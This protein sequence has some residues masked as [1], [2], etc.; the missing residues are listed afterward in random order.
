MK[1]IVLLMG[2]LHLTTAE[3]IRVDGISP[4]CFK[5][6]LCR[7]FEVVGAVISVDKSLPFM[8]AN[9]CCINFTIAS[10]DEDA[11]FMARISNQTILEGDDFITFY[12]DNFKMIRNITANDA[13]PFE[14]VHFNSPRISFE[15]YKDREYRSIYEIIVSVYHEGN[16]PVC[17]KPNYFRCES[18]K[19]ICID[20]N[21]TCDKFPHCPTDRDEN[22]CDGISYETAMSYDKETVIIVFVFIVGTILMTLIL[23]LILCFC[24]SKQ[25]LTE[26]FMAIFGYRNETK[27]SRMLD[28]DRLITRN[29]EQAYGLIN[30]KN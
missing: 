10:F 20:E 15:F 28:S 12:E 25:K 18:N 1:I 6:P 22:I 14:M 17:R 5:R 7:E 19:S 4:T 29:H 24:K 23:I 16:S 21:L 13:N 27:N 11:Y 3:R 8:G 26:T 2:I 30:E 9:M